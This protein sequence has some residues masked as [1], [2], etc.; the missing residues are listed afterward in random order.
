MNWATIISSMV[1]SAFMTLAVMYFTV[2]RRG[3][4]GANDRPSGR[5]GATLD[6]TRPKPDEALR[7]IEERFR[8]VADTA[9]MLIW[10]SGPDKLCNFFNKGWLDFTGRS[11]EKELGDG[12]AKG[13]H[14]DDLAGCLKTYVES[15]DARR[16]FTIEY[17]LRRHDGEYRWISDVGVPRFDSRRNFLGYI[18]SAVDLTERMQ[19]EERFRLVVEASPNGIILVDEQGRITLVNAQTE[20]LFG[21]SRPELIGE[22]VD[23]LVPERWRAGHTS[24]RDRFGKVAGARMMGARGELFG[25]R[26]DGTEF[27]IEIGLSPIQGQ[28]GKQVLA[29]VVDITARKEAEAE[30]LRQRVELAHVARVSTMGELA[31]SVAHELNQ[32]LAAILANTEAA[33]LFLNQKPPALGELR[34]ILADIRKDDERAGEVIR[35]MRTLLRKH[36]LERRPLTINSVV[37]DVFRVVSSDA[38]LRQTTISA[39]LGPV[40]PEIIGDRVHLQQ[41]VLNL[42]L[43]GMDAMAGQP[44]ERRR[45]SVRTRA[46][47]DGVNGAV[48]LAVI[49]TGHGIEPDKLERVFEPF[50]TTKP[51]G[52]GMGLSISHTIIEAHRGR[53]WAE[54]NA[55][56]GATFYVALPVAK[57]REDT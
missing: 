12:W 38:A 46:G 13:V 54:N 31:A 19:S 2:W 45:L 47:V 10:M 53:I 4:S 42:I 41:V 35:R 29:V 22:P 23:L 18:G 3:R 48:E 36:E 55:S 57:E 11:L 32:P 49:D 37:E 52:M 39:D 30:A 17:R 6:I 50:Y 5:P 21:Y 16:P 20:K 34:D 28:D 15:F 8:T 14:P 44:R 25:R 56:G 27:P 40:L 51:H 26:K 24:H 43:N 1:A 9:P 7:E 33:D